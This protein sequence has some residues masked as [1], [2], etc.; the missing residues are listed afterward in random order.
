MFFLREIFLAV[1][2]ATSG[3]FAALPPPSSDPWPVQS[4]RT[5]PYQPPFLNVTKAGQTG[6]G[7]LFLAP[8]DYTRGSDAL[9]IYSDDGQLVWY[10]PGSAGSD[11][12]FFTIHPQQ[13]NCEPVLTY[14]EGAFHIEGYGYGAI[15][16]LNSSYEEIGKV[17][18]PSTE[19]NTFKTS[20][21]KNYSSYVDLHEDII[22]DEGTMLI[23]A[24]NVTQ[25]DLSPIGGP[26]DGW[27][28]DALVYEVD[29]NTN[30]V[31]FRWSTVEHENDIPLSD[32]MIPLQAQ[33]AGHNATKPYP[34]AHLNTVSKYGDNYLISARYLCSVYLVHRNGTML[35]KLHV[36]ELVNISLSLLSLL[37]LRS[38]IGAKRR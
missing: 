27:V 10:R 4:F 31:L 36:S 34:Y 8:I 17:T 15:T 26:K 37:T 19:E 20:S 1:L 29:I 30:E 38:L 9:A 5:T 22:T 33:G 25:M 14:W 6:F 23:T 2:A 32:S 11:E 24:V 16:I 7:Y 28:Q 12:I 21:S 18:L 35:W 3:S 13:W